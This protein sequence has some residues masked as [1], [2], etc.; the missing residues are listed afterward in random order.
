MSST[1]NTR[2]DGP[3]DESFLVA[4]GVIGVVGCLLAGLTPLV[5][6][7]SPAFTGS[8]VSSSLLGV[9][10]AAQNLR[11]LRRNGDV[12]LAPAALTTVFGGWFMA[13]PLLYDVGFI[14]TAGTQLSGLLV[15]AFGLYLT[16]ARIAPSR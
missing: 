4:G 3:G 6:G 5:G 14:A 8:V 1:P 16:L 9:V 7:A 2:R 13:A 11:L 10:F 12:A 15:S